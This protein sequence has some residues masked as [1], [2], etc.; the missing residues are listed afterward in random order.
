MPVRHLVPLRAASVVFLSLPWVVFAI[1]WMRLPWAV[2]LLAVLAV[3]AIQ[4]LRAVAAAPV[5]GAPALHPI[6]A[7]ISPGAL[8]AALLLAVA[9]SALSGAGGVGYQ[10][11]PDWG[12]KNA[13]MVDLVR[14]PWPVSFPNGQVVNYYFALYLLPPLV[15]KAAGW[16]AGQWAMFA[17]VLVGLALS[18]LWLY[19]LAGRWGARA[20]TLFL[21]FGGLDVVGWLLHWHQL[22]RL[23]QSIEWW[24]PDL[25]FSS[26]TTAIFWVPQHALSAWL[27]TSLLIDEVTQLGTVRFAGLFVGLCYLWSPFVAVGLVPVAIIAWLMSGRRSVISFANLACW[28]LMTIL[29]MALYASH[30]SGSPLDSGAG[31]WARHFSPT[32]ILEM[33][34]E[35]VIELGVIAVA[36]AACWRRLEREWRIVAVVCGGSAILW[37]LFPDA[38]GH[39]NFTT[40]SSLPMLLLVF[41]LVLR[42]LSPDSPRAVRG[43]LAAAL[44][45]GTVVSFQEI[46]RSLQRYPATIPAPLPAGD[47]EA[48]SARHQGEFLMPANGRLYRLFYRDARGGPVD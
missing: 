29:V 8:A 12:N 40:R 44:M 47:I 11:M 22:P 18:L 1:T 17:Q 4:Y 34:A 43:A 30:R 2:L 41:L 26:S 32:G 48:L 21:V 14:Y 36:V 37:V 46:T 15:A 5:A 23:G 7:T 3:A 24:A 45:V 10:N 35:L 16:S 31:P 6:N 27:L 38:V 20:M 39:G 42:M 33:V 9:W 19:T 13:L 28:P 25:Q